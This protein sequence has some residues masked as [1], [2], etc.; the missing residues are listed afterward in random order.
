MYRV[1]TRSYIQIFRPSTLWLIALSRKVPLS[2]PSCELL[3]N[4]TLM[5]CAIRTTSK[6]RLTPLNIYFIK[7]HKEFGKHAPECW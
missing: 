5:C 4:G 7:L 2:L 1:K 6:F 3:P